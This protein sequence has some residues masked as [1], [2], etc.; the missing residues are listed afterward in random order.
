M[1]SPMNFFNPT[2]KAASIAPN[3]HTHHHNQIMEEDRAATNLGPLV[4]DA[5][6]ED[7]VAPPKQPKRRFVGK[8]TA[9]KAAGK[10]SDPNANIEDSSA[11]QGVISHSLYM[12]CI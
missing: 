8:R 2:K 3:F 9:E 11:I 12:Y 5:L 7:P 1:L 4:D 6:R 10:T